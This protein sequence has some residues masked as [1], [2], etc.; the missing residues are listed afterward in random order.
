MVYFATMSFNANVFQGRRK[1]GVTSKL[2]IILHNR[3]EVRN[4]LALSLYLAP[5]HGITYLFLGAYSTFLIRQIH[6]CIYQSSIYYLLFN[7]LLN[8]CKYVDTVDLLLYVVLSDLQ[9][10]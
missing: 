4:A 2:G 5:V 3:E 8:F 6:S 1:H 7:F 9:D 10:C